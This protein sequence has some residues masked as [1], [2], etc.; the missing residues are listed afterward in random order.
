[1]RNTT[2]AKILAIGCGFMKPLFPFPDAKSVRYV[3][4]AYA[5]F[6]CMRL[7]SPSTPA[8]LVMFSNSAR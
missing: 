4:N 7:I 2:G 5:F 3:A 1:V 6:S 8:V